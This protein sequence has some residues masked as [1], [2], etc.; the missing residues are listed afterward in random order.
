MCL[1]ALLA[2]ERCAGTIA[3]AGAC[4]CCWYRLLLLARKSRSTQGHYVL[5]RVGG[6]RTFRLDL[7]LLVTDLYGRI[8]E[9]QALSAW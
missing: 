5:A 7:G 4:C 9:R 2:T 1:P 6:A 3:T 8:I